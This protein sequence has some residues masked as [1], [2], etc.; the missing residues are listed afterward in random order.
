MDRNER[1]FIDGHMDYLQNGG[2]QNAREVDEEERLK[3]AKEQDAWE[4][5]V[6]ADMRERSKR[7]PSGHCY[8][9][10]T[11]ETTNYKKRGK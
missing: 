7:E 6:F 2:G 5:F 9:G 4:Q 3:E 10:D 8:M 1:A 11:E